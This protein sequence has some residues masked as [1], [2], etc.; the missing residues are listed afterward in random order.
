MVPLADLEEI[1]VS[2]PD[3]VNLI[4]GTVREHDVELIISLATVQNFTDHSIHV[5]KVFGNEV[6]TFYAVASISGYKCDREPR[7]VSIIADNDVRIHNVSVYERIVVNDLVRHK[8]V[9]SFQNIKI[10][11]LY[12]NI[13]KN[14][15][16]LT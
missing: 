4:V 14:A 16:N 6:T 2:H 7:L 3:H 1:F 12:Y 10:H 8:D 13:I 5:L 15:M 11:I 9:P